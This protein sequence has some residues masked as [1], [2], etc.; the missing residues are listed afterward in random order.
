MSTCTQPA[1]P[2]R[3]SGESHE[4]LLH[5]GRVNGRGVGVHVGMLTFETQWLES[6]VLSSSRNRALSTRGQ[7]DVNLHRLTGAAGVVE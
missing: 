3:G 7:I 2:Y 4:R 6:T 1:P 5:G